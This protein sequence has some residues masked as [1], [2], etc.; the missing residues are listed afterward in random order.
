VLHGW[1]NFYIMAH[2]HSG[3]VV[4]LSR[5]TLIKQVSSLWIPWTKAGSLHWYGSLAVVSDEDKARI[6]A[7]TATSG[8]ARRHGLPAVTFFGSCRAGTVRLDWRLQ[9]INW[10]KLMRRIML[11][12][13]RLW[14]RFKLA[15]KKRPVPSPGLP[16]GLDEFARLIS[17][18]EPTALKQL[19]AGLARPVVVRRAA[20]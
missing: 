3:Q 15:L 5:W 4:F 10:L 2:L 12:R 6:V 9:T 1:D 14:T 11:F 16:Y 13:F 20:T 8:V 19:A 7:Q 17:S 18:R